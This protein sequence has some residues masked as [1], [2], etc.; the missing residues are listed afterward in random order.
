MISI[1]AYLRS[2]QASIYRM[3][4]YTIFAL[5]GCVVS[6]LIAAEDSIKQVQ[7][8]D[9]EKAW[10]AEHPEV[11]LAPDPVFAPF[12]YFDKGGQYVGMAADFVQL[13]QEKTGLKINVQR[14]KDWD[15]VTAK[16]KAREVDLFVATRT[17]ERETYMR[18]TKPAIVL[19]WTIVAQTDSDA[20]I[21]LADLRERSVGV[22][23][24]Y[25]TEQRLKKEHP[26]LLLAPAKNIPE[27]LR[28][29]SSGSIDVLILNQAEATY[30]IEE[31]GFTNLRFAG[32]LPYKT[33]LAL[34]S[35][36][37]WPELNSILQKGLDAIT[38]QER[39]AISRKWISTKSA[40]VFNNPTF[41]LLI[42]GAAALLI[43]T[44]ALGFGIN[45]ALK[46]QVKQKTEDLEQEL[47]RRKL[48]EHSLEKH[49]NQ[50]EEKVNTR[51]AELGA[52]KERFELAISAT[53]DGLWDWD[54]ST[55][56]VFHS[57]RYLTMLGYEPDELPHTLETFLNLVHREDLQRAEAITQ[58]HFDHGPDSYDFEIRMRTKDNSYRWVHSRGKIVKRNAE[59]KPLRAVGTH[60]DITERRQQD[61]AIR[62]NA[63]RLRQLLEVT[64]IGVAIH[65]EEGLDV[66]FTNA[67]MREMFGITEQETRMVD[68]RAHY[69]DPLKYDQ[70]QAEFQDKRVLQNKE[71]HLK[72]SDNSPFWALLSVFPINFEGAPARL[73]WLYDI[74]ELK[75]TEAA[76]R[77]ARE[78][79]ESANRAKSQFLSSMSHELRTPL[80]GVLGYAQLLQ[81]DQNLNKD[82]HDSLQAIENCGQHLLSLIN[83]VLDFSKIEADQMEVH[84]TNVDLPKLIRSVYDI[85]LQRAKSK[86]LK[87][88]L[89]LAD[90]LPRG[91]YADG[92]KLRQVIVN[93]LG[94]AVKFTEDGSVTLK[95]EKAS[96]D[97]LRFSVIDTGIG[98]RPQKLEHIFDPFKQE[99][100]GIKEGGTGLG[101]S[102]SKRLVEM[103]G[104]SITVTSTPQKGSCFTFTHPLTRADV[105]T[106]INLDKEVL[107]D[108]APMLAPD[109][110]ARALIVDDRAANR[111]ILNKLLSGSG[112]QTTEA[113]N[114]REALEAL[115]Q[116]SYTIVFMDIQ[117]PEMDGIEATKQIRSTLQL[118]DLPIVAITA[119][120]FPGSKEQFVEQGFNDYIGKPFRIG[121]IFQTISELTKL[122]FSSQE[123]TTS[124][125]AATELL[126][127]PCA[128]AMAERLKNAAEIGDFTE[129]TKIVDE[130]KIRG[131]P[132]FAEE[133]NSFINEFDFEGIKSFAQQLTDTQT[134]V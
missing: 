24:G 23:S 40:S 42:G 77:G 104:G 131:C 10:L 105:N 92:T 9:A 56:K 50:L 19:P 81:R 133:L 82:H 11:T 22:I 12:E 108:D 102:I 51:T 119:S 4:C 80:N 55:N 30:Y 99:E 61:E 32:F 132:K 34:G 52:E 118:N 27:G 70:V 39:R 45:Q 107:N 53:S 125:A 65:R 8:T 100:G 43:L 122:N 35:R 126:E 93:L 74:T 76:L 63:M 83:D 129:A 28:A 26:E 130:L 59:G 20:K 123:T 134:T 37:D 106:M 46:R 101:L 25:V 89:D 67:R 112:F 44:I 103:L 116:S 117:M 18:F 16:A 62:T 64:P 128:H 3:V 48:A 97:Q 96:K 124:P 120:V 7:L 31:E 1:T 84:M 54:I 72:K 49:L 86:G 121:E 41:W 87:M 68:P 47:E 98:I 2:S 91:L 13:V 90:N 85:V 109:Q 5:W 88:E 94:N 71:V 29:V 38:E 78:Q 69:L 110:F 114:G 113:L 75:G 6:P 115:K 95:V 17:D 58:K 111:D 73:C 36:T 15:E 79:A 14:L 127:S 57:P 21:T 60:T 66:L 33:E